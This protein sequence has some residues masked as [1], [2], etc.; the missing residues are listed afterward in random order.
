MGRS[1][2]RVTE[3]FQRI[4][5]KQPVS[6]LFHVLGRNFGG[7]GSL[8]AYLLKK[9]KKKRKTWTRIDLHPVKASLLLYI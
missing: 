4:I 6:L 2:D 1:T 3:T 8:S 5:D 9:K 7:V